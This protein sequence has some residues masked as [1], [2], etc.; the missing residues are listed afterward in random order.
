[1]PFHIVCHKNTCINQISIKNNYLI[2]ALL[3]KMGSNQKIRKI[4]NK[5]E[6]NN[7]EKKF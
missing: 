1:M 6:I 5:L 7:N 3:G 4:R 2:F